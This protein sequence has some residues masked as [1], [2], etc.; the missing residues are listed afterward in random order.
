MKNIFRVLYFSSMIY[1]AGCA[2]SEDSMLLEDVD[3]I[4]TYDFVGGYQDWQA[5]ISDF[6]TSTLDSTSFSFYNSR[7]PSNL[8]WQGYGLSVTADNPHGDLFYFFKKHITGLKA[9]KAYN[10]KLEFMVYSQLDS[11]ELV[12]TGENIYLK[13]GAVNFEPKLE[14]IKNENFKDYKVLNVDKGAANHDSGED[15]VNLGSIV[16]F[17]KSQP[18][19]FSGNNLK[20][21]IRVTSDANGGSWIVIGADSGIRNRLTFGLIAIT[22]YYSEIN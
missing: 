1:L 20:N 4:S 11:G 8:P 10:L 13:V 22:I 21:P 16:K 18:D 12:K 17:T 6:P 7:T 2:Q 3:L 9:N 14:R 5:G 19:A 15:L